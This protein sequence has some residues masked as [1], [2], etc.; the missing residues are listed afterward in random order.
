MKERLA[1]GIVAGV[2]FVGVA[3][4]EGKPF[5]A[6]SL[7]DEII[8]ID[9]NQAIAPYGRLPAAVADTRPMAVKV[10]EETTTDMRVGSGG[11]LSVGGLRV[12]V[13]AAHVVARGARSCT[14]TQAIVDLDGGQGAAFNE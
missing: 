12:V 3:G 14:N 2:A 1:A 10:Q 9:P 8:N 13:T 11:V 6:L 7:G 5:D 4:C